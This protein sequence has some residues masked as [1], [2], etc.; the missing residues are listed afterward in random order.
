MIRRRHDHRRRLPGRRRPYTLRGIRRVPCA[1]CGAP[2]AYQ[3]SACALD[4]RWCGL[5]AQCDIALNA[6]VL[7][8][9]RIASAAQ[10]LARY[11]ARVRAQQ[12]QQAA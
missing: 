3:W 9:F 1:R 10:L 11:I 4:N 5:C 6:F 8:F 12:G 2:S 7:R